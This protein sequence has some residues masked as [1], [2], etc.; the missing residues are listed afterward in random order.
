MK[1]FQDKF[2]EISWETMAR[3]LDEEKSQYSQKIQF[4]K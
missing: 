1:I 4:T 3:V 2:M